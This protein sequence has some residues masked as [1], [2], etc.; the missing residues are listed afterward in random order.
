MEHIV[1]LNKIKSIF[2]NH[3][4]VLHGGIFNDFSLLSELNDILVKYLKEPYLSSFKDITVILPIVNLNDINFVIQNCND[5]MFS[6]IMTYIY[7]KC[8]KAH[9]KNSSEYIFLKKT[10]QSEKIKINELITKIQSP[11]MIDFLQKINIK[12]IELEEH[13]KASLSDTTFNIMKNIN[14]EETYDEVTFLKKNN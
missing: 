7:Y 11:E 13:K 12:F 4:I 14:F 3:E 10:I 9:L 8:C 1:L 2:Y 5:L 6:Y